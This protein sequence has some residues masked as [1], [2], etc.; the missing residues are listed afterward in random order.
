MRLLA[1]PELQMVFDATQELLSAL[2]VADREAILGGNARRF[3]GLDC[4][5]ADSARA[6]I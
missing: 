4:A 6:S 3:Y 5:S 1:S 2:S